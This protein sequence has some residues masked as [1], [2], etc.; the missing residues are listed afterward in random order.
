M[1]EH[2]YA[3]VSGSYSDYSVHCIFSTEELANE[4]KNLLDEALFRRRL[5][6]GSWSIAS[7]QR[8]YK[9]HEVE[10]FQFFTNIPT[11]TMESV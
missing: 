8:A 7:A 5:N 2:V 3:V 10:K 1:T 4:Y 9:E 11:V 6:H